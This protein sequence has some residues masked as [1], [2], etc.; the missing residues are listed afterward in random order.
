MSALRVPMDAGIASS[1]I[2]SFARFL[3]HCA[4]STQVIVSADDHRRM[5]QACVRM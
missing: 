1:S 5:Q 4:I 2:G 3:L